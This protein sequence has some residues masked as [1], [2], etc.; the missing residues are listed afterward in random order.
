MLAADG[1]SNRQIAEQ[2]FI[3]Q[4]TVETHCGTPST[5]L[6]SHRARTCPR[7]WPT[8]VSETSRVLRTIEVD[9]PDDPGWRTTPG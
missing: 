7:G 2:L 5:S 4:A 3:T 6:A 9:R 8:G 1:R